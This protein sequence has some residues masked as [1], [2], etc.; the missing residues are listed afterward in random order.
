MM[1]PLVVAFI[2]DA[3]AKSP[4]KHFAVIPAKAGIQLFRLVAKYLDPGFQRGDDF[5]R[6]HLT[7]RFRVQT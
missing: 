5:L 2:Y 7:F 3:L 6:M 1:K 4:I